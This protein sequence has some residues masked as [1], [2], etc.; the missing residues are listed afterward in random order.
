MKLIPE[1]RQPRRIDLYHEELELY[2][3][4]VN[5]I[6]IYDLNSQRLIDA[7]YDEQDD[8]LS[9]IELEANER[10]VGVKSK[11]LADRPA[12]HLDI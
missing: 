10:I 1:G 12:A 4:R 9:R 5:C 11:V 7:G 3:Q 8:Q 6:M 2:G